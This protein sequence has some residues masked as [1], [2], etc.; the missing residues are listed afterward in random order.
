MD[1]RAF[2]GIE[3]LDDNRW[4]LRVTERLITPGNFLFGGCGLAAGLVALEH[5]GGRPTVW[6]AAHYL[7][8]AP[9]GSD[10]IITTEFPAVGGRVTQARAV[11]SVGDDEIMTVVASLGTGDLEATVPW[12]VMP[13]V[14][15]PDEC[16]PRQSLH[17]FGETIFSHLDT[18]VA[19]GRSFQELDGQPGSPRSAVW[20]R[21]ADHPDFSAATLAIFGD[22]LA[23]GAT[24]PLG[25]PVMGR[26]L[27][28]TLRMA[29]LVPTEWVLIHMRMHAVH[30]GFAHGTAFLWSEDGVLLG[31]ASQSIS[32]KRWDPSALRGS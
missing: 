25:F 21:L 28:N 31:T 18:R 30:H 9:T 15:P 3:Q 32:L 1:A 8:H 7:S 12:D 4:R 2:L 14:A 27:D 24:E 16:A 13:D 23:G 17:F 20:S 11:A 6:A 26:S 10:V 19:L 29:K 22:H 5:D